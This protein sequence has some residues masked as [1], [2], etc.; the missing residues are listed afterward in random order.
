MGRPEAAPETRNR[1]RKVLPGK[2]GPRKNFTLENE[3]SN[4][5][6]NS[7]EENFTARENEK[8]IW[9]GNQGCTNRCL[10]WDS[11]EAVQPIGICKSD[12]VLRT[13]PATKI[14]K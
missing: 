14:E 12:L 13:R 10:S 9:R 2:I 7:L 4:G 1:D 5:D 3:V 6:K 8:Q 11:T